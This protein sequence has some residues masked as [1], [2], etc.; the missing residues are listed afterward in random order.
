MAIQ[1]GK[2]VATHVP[3]SGASCSEIACT[4]YAPPAPD[5]SPS[6]TL[7]S[8]TPAGTVARDRAREREALAM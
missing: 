8:G 1:R 7:V 3:P 5:W 6:S 4:A 2:R